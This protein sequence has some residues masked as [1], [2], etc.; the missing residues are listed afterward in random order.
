MESSEWPTEV[1]H[2]AAT[3][4]VKLQ[5]E[6]DLATAA[7]LRDHLSDLYERG[8]RHFVLDG[9]NVAFVDSVGLSVILGLH[10]RCRD[11]AGT[12]VITSPSGVMQRTLEVAGLYDV[13]DVIE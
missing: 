3:A 1:D 8:S 13:L 9:S 11:E 7:A 12:L 4:T 5:G 6:L 10:R 2:A